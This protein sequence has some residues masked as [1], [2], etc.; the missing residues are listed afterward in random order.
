[1]AFKDLSVKHKISLLTFLISTLAIVIAVLIFY[2]YDKNMYKKK[3]QRDVAVLAEVI[4]RHNDANLQFGGKKQANNYLEALK[5]ETRIKRAILFDTLHTQPFAF[6]TRNNKAPEQLQEFRATLDTSYFKNHSL[7][8]FMPVYS[9][10]TVIGNIYL[11]ANMEEFRERI[12]HFLSIIA[13]MILAIPVALF[14]L[15]TEMQK[16]ITRPVMKLHKAMKNA[17][18]EQDYT[19]RVDPETTDEIGQLTMGFNQM[20]GQIEEQN[21]QLR[22]A[23]KRAEDS[24]KAKDQFLANMSHEIRTPMNTI[25][26]MT[27]ILLDTEINKKQENY[28]N[29][30]KISASNL[31]VIINDILDFSKI[32][33]GKLQL[34]H[35]PF[36]LYKKLD[37]LKDTIELKASEKDIDLRF[38]KDDNLP[39]Y[40][41]GD[42][43]RLNQILLNLLTNAL[44]FTNVGYIS[45]RVQVQS[46]EGSRYQLYFEVEDTGIGIKPEMQT[47]IFGSF[48]QASNSTSRKYGGTGLGLAISRQLVELSGGSIGLESEPGKGSRFF[49][50]VPFTEVDAEQLESRDEGTLEKLKADY[51][52]YLQSYGPL[53]ILLVEDNSMNQLL[54]KTLL[55]KNKFTVG[56]ANNGF[57]ALEEIEKKHYDLV[58]MDI[59]MPEKDGYQ[60]TIEI[61]KNPNTAIN[62]L[63]IIAL[64]AA[65]TKNEINKSLK[66]GMDDFIS[67]PFKYEVLLMKILSKTLKK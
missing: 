3:L 13:A 38:E 66:V 49:F 19:T 6:Y 12:K 21:K 52:H 7:H 53:K 36:D 39:R 62:S 23:K 44:K 10:G 35:T 48:Q 31:L 43:V 51:E 63:P 15:T 64:T 1:M 16:I 65:A 37:E 9:E 24:L 33:S 60:T 47:N 11:Q 42:P 2:Q 30:I 45:L 18:E 57:E 22:K 54:A 58:L 28:L 5:K 8:V 50:Q 20:L 55:K 34:E 40:V 25:L 4:G 26:G 29:N 56:L 14:F 32:Q 59:H 61:R 67:K 17:G 27:N 41:M 46:K